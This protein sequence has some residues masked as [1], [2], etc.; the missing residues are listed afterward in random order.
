MKTTELLSSNTEAT[1]AI[2]NVATRVHYKDV[3]SIVDVTSMMH[4]RL[5][6]EC[7]SMQSVRK[8]LSELASAYN[9]YVDLKAQI[10]SRSKRIQRLMAVLGDESVSNIA[11]D[12]VRAETNL[13]GDP[14]SLRTDLPLWQA[15]K[16]YLTFA[17]QTKVGDIQQFFGATNYEVSRQAIESALRSHTSTFRVA[18]KGRDKYISLKKQNA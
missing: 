5:E 1:I 17:G 18:R 7:A 16:E 9:R 10:D 12:A 14:E 11:K 2:D 8:E 3:P 6:H 4:Q 15:V 13:Q